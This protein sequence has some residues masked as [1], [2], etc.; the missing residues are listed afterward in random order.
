M[1]DDDFWTRRRFSL[2]QGIL[3]WVAFMVI[4]LTLNTLVSNHQHHE[5]PKCTEQP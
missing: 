4:N 1:N 5:D 2:A 3:W